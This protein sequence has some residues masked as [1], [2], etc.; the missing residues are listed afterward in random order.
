MICRPNALL[1]S[2]CPTVQHRACCTCIGCLG[3]RSEL[4]GSE[5]AG[6][7]LGRPQLSRFPHP[8]A[9]RRPAGGEQYA[10]VPGP[11]LRPPQRTAR[12]APEPAQ[13]GGTRFSPWPHRSSADTPDRRTIRMN[14]SA[15]YAPAA[16]SGSGKNFT[17]AIRPP[18]KP[19]SPSAAVS[20]SATSDSPPSP[21]SL[22]ASS[23]SDTCLFR[24]TSTATTR[25]P[26]VIATRPST[27]RQGD[28]WPRPPPV[29]TLPPK[30]CNRFVH[31]ALQIA[32]ITLHVGLGTFQPVRVEKVEDHKLHR[33]VVRDSSRGGASDQP[34]ESRGQA[35]GGRGHHH[36]PHPR[37]RRRA[38]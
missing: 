8:A 34:G 31:A 4:A 13:S 29:C 15:W 10:R 35:R 9:A 17:L 27:P 21:I 23:A 19:R 12:P 25:Q 32:E 37:V 6:S 7:E 3:G 16:R 18:S 5:L 33:G 1:R 2:P 22:P 36:R 30:S 20:A 14:G 24:P 11:S 26:T 38:F 28:R